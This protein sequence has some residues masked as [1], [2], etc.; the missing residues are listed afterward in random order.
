MGEKAEHVCAFARRIGN[1]RTIV[2]VPRFFTSL[3]NQPKGLPFGREVW[4]ESR[5]IVSIAEHGARYRNIFTDEIITAEEYRDATAL[6]LS[7][8]FASFPVAMIER[9]Y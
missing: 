5:L 1:E 4:G 7:E 2:A 9:L 6:N 3:F 8:L